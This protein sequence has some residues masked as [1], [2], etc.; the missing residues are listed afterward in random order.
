MFDMKTICATALCAVVATTQAYAAQDIQVN[1][2]KFGLFNGSTPAI[3]KYFVSENGADSLRS[4][5]G[6]YTITG[7][8][9]VRHNLSELS[10]H[11]KIRGHAKYRNGECAVF[12][13]GIT[14]AKLTSSWVRGD[15]VTGYWDGNA[16]VGKTIATFGANGQY[17]NK[18]G[19]SHVA[20]VLAAWRSAPGNG[21]IDSVW[22][23]D[24]NYVKGEN[25]GIIGR[26]RIDTKGSSFVSNL[27]NYYIV[28]Q[29]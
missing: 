4:Q 7:E 25:N 19:R 23:L 9:T 8:P 22:V 15:K 20:I 28:K 14:N 16:L 21:P 12:V 10:A 1:Y 26:H 6:N 18:P 24:S 2:A 17:E 3:E 13:Q 5:V 27:N 29:N 11:G